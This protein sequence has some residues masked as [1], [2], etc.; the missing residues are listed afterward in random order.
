MTAQRLRSRY[1]LNRDEDGED[2]FKLLLG[3][4][5]KDTLIR[6]IEGYDPPQASSSRVL[7]ALEFFTASSARH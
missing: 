2:R 3:K 5:D 4:T 1:L 7:A 6:L